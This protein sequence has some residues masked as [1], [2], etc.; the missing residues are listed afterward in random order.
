M[1]QI[2]RLFDNRPVRM[3]L[4]RGEP[5]FV[6]KDVCEVLGYT[7]P[8]KAMADHCKGVSN[9]YPLGEDGVTNRYTIRDRFGREQDVRIINEPDLYRLIIRSNMPAAEPFERW[10][11]EEVLPS[12]RKYGKYQIDPALRHSSISARSTLTNQWHQHGARAPYHY[13]NLTRTEY[14]AL[15]FPK[16]LRKEYMTQEQIAELRVFEALESLKLIKN[17]FIDGFANLNKSLM[18]TCRMLPMFT[19]GIAA[20][21]P[22]GVSA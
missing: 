1:K 11:F 8:N 5:W 7:N 3:I 19:S 14:K 22:E 15:G 21:A 9:R 20:G 2:L 18:E 10:V 16:D 12:I 4:L 6:G 17:P 13:V